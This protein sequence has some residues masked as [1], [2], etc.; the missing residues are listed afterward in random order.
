LSGDGVPVI[1]ERSLNPP[2]RLASIIPENSTLRG[3]P[4]RLYT[5]TLEL[6]VHHSLFFSSR[7]R[8]VGRTLKNFFLGTFRRW[9]WQ[10]F[11]FK[12]LQSASTNN[13]INTCN[14]CNYLYIQLQA[15]RPRQS[16]FQQ[17]PIKFLD[18]LFI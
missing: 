10:I 17:H 2:Q 9:C 11:F 18:T 15:A 16:E 13:R 8:L 6:P 7:S 14:L 4:S 5:F 3:T 1:R 12:Y